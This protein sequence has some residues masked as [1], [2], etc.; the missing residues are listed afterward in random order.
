MGGVRVGK[1]HPQ[2]EVAHSPYMEDVEALVHFYAF[3][4]WYIYTVSVRKKVTLKSRRHREY[5][6]ISRVCSVR[7]YTCIHFLLN[8]TRGGG[9]FSV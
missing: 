8:R 2:R 5:E 4:R 6:S 3:V 7:V 1:D 9:K